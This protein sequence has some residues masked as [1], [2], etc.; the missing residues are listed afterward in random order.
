[1]PNTFMA[2]KNLRHSLSSNALPSI[3]V[4]HKKFGNSP[5]TFFVALK[6]LIYKSKSR[7]IVIC[8]YKIRE[9]VIFGPIVVKIIIKTLIVDLIVGFE[10]FLLPFLHN[11][12]TYKSVYIAQ[13]VQRDGGEH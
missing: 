3:A 13:Y 12:P 1:M 4:S 11:A 8:I 7:Q 6:I 2:I 10:F 5:V 9:A